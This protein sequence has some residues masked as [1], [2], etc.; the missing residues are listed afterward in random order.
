MPRSR[1]ISDAELEVLK[2]L[3]KDGPSTVH[4][5]QAR[6]SRRKPK[7]AYTTVLTLLTR[8]REKGFVASEKSGV[9]LEFRAVVSREQLLRRRLSELADKLCD[10]TASPL[11]HALV[12]DRRFSPEEIEEL[13]LLIDK[14]ESD[15]PRK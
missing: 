12:E 5:V 10:G 3:W 4:G 14:L 11:V 9:A 8:L 6:L 15:K 1:P 13:R 7:R 2:I